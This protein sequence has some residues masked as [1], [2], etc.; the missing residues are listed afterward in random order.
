MADRETRRSCLER[1]TPRPDRCIFTSGQRRTPA[2]WSINNG[3]LYGIKVTGSAAEV[4]TTGIDGVSGNLDSQAFTLHN[5]GNVTS[6]SGASLQSQSVANGVTEFLRPEDI[7]WDPTNAAK[8]YFVTTDRFD[9]GA[10]VGASR[11]W[12]LEF[13]N[14][15]DFTMGGTVKMLI[16]GSGS[17]DGQMFDN[18][19]VTRDGK[20]LLQEDPGGQSYLAKTWMYDI[21]TGS[22]AEFL[23]SDSSRFTTGSPNF[24]TIDEESSG[25]ID[26]SDI[27]NDG[28]KY[29][30]ANCRPTTASRANWSRAASSM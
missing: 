28:T 2:P 6:T 8:A 18:M 1:T 13:T 24:L 20:I 23:V 26:I 29:Y 25:I 15:D 14:T 9:T 12:E 22:L 7:G 16:E 17:A 5:F 11:L 3:S 4:R 30:L 21:A 27:M 19:T 10:N